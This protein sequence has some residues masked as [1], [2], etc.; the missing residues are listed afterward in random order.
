MGLW[1]G[2]PWPEA[3]FGERDAG[4]L[5]QSQL[6]SSFGLTATHTSILGMRFILIENQDS[7]DYTSLQGH[8]NSR[9]PAHVYNL[10]VIFLLLSPCELYV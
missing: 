6:V 9:L 8:N 3:V 2:Q 4:N 5:F 10:H 1:G 7:P